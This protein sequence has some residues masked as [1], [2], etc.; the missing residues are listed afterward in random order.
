MGGGDVESSFEELLQLFL[1]ELGLFGELFLK[2]FVL[3]LLRLDHLLET[4]NRLFKSLNL[5]QV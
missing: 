5:V 3:S 2:E 1:L 4:G